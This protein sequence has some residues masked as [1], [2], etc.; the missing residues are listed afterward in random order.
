MAFMW[1]YTPQSRQWWYR[2]H[3]DNGKDNENDKDNDDDDDDADFLWNIIEE[4]R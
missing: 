4:D 1:S 2:W 3:K